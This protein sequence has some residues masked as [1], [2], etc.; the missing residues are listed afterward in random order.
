MPDMIEEKVVRARKRHVCDYCGA[1][2]EPGEEY[3]RAK[4]AYEGTVYEWKAHKECI[5]IASELWDY[6]DPDENGLTADEFS[7]AC[8]E[9]CK[10]FICP[11]CE[12]YDPD[13][14]DCED[15]GVY[16]ISKIAE[17]LQENELTRKRSGYAYEFRLVKRDKKVEV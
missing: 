14:G 1:Y 13:S 6:I 16:C 15:D 11:D 8:Q 9:F 17:C 3:N 2:I 10:T 7:D 4:L 12:K 5:F